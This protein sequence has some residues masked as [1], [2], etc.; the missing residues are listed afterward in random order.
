MVVFMLPRSGLVGAVG[1]NGLPGDWAA[2]QQRNYN[3]GINNSS[4]RNEQR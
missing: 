1:G 4:Q 2:P 3:N